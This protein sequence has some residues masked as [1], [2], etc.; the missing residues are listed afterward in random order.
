M[1]AISTSIMVM[2]NIEDLLLSPAAKTES[3]FLY[4][5]IDLLGEGDAAASCTVIE[6]VDLKLDIRGGSNGSPT[7]LTITTEWNILKSPN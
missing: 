6:P 2:T 4:I 7:L 1:E 5:L 3:R